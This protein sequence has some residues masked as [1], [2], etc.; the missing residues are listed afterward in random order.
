MTNEDRAST[1]GLPANSNSWFSTTGQS[2]YILNEIYHK[3]EWV[4]FAGYIVKWL[5][6]SQ[7][8]WR[9]FGFH[10]FFWFFRKWIFDKS[11]ATISCTKNFFLHV[12]FFVYKF[13]RDLQPFHFVFEITFSKMRKYVLGCFF[14]K[15]CSLTGCYQVLLF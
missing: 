9:W 15:T 13:L 11:T 1:S 12:K 5:I 7:F 8:R 4:G 3:T 14:I 2:D 10:V 6:Q